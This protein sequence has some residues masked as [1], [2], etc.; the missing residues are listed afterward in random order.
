MNPNIFYL[1]TNQPFSTPTVMALAAKPL[2]IADTSGLGQ[3]T[4]NLSVSNTKSQWLILF[5]FNTHPLI[6][7]N[8]LYVTTIGIVTV[9]GPDTNFQAIKSSL[10][11]NYIGFTI[12]GGT[13][14]KTYSVSVGANLSDGTSVISHTLFIN[15]IS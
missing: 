7:N 8:G 1:L 3:N 2:V 9:S 5:N 6:A 12:V 10:Y 14:G 11:N 15:I 13:T 4:Y